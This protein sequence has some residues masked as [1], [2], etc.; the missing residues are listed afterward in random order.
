ERSAQSDPK[1][2]RQRPHHPDAVVRG[3][4]A[5]VRRLVLDVAPIRVGRRIR[6][7]QV[8]PADVVVER[9][10]DADLTSERGGRRATGRPLTAVPRA[11]RSPACK[12][13]NTSSPPGSRTPGRSSDAGSGPPA[14][15]IID[16]IRSSIWNGIGTATPRRYATMP[17]RAS[18]VP[19]R[20]RRRMAVSSI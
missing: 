5:V 18:G 13:M 1:L 19:P 14:I 17:R 7:H 20:R 9:I 12:A 2:G 3:L 11:A 10:V 8:G 15:A 6:H 16:P 4:D